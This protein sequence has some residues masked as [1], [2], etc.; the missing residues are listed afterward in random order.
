LHF[1]GDGVALANL[2]KP[3][4]RLASTLGVST[5]QLKR[6]DVTAKPVMTIPSPALLS[7][8][9]NAA[10]TGELRVPI[11]KTYRLDQI[12]QALKD[13]GAGALGKLAVTVR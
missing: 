9:A 13:F 4:G 5:E 7:E 10:A 1:A 8:L 11:T 3:G 6:K 12:G 2:L